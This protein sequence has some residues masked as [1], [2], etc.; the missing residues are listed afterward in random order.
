MWS[1]YRHQ[2]PSQAAQNAVQRSRISLALASDLEARSIK[3]T[4]EIKETLERNHLVESFE[5]TVLGVQK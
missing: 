5:A 2:G 3:V 4:K 1:P